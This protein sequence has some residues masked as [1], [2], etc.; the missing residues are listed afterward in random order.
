MNNLYPIIA[1]NRYKQERKYFLSYILTFAILF[2][3]LQPNIAQKTREVVITGEAQFATGKEIRLIVFDDLL[4]YQAVTVASTKISKEGSFRLTYKTNQIKLVQLAIQTSKAEFLVIPGKHYNFFID[5][6]LELFQLLDPLSYGGFLQIIPSE[7]DTTELNY[8]IRKFELFFD[9]LNEQFYPELIYHKNLKLR[10]SMATIL[11]EKFQFY[12]DPLDFYASYLY[13]SF[14]ILDLIIYQKSIDTIYKKYLDNEYILYDNPAYMTFFNSFY[15]NYLYNSPRISKELLTQFINQTPDY[16]AIF[17]E[18]GRDPSLRNERIRELVIIK[19]LREFYEDAQFSQ[20]NILILLEF[21]LKNTHFPEHKPIIKNIIIST[22][23]LHYNSE[24]PK[25]SLKEANGVDFKLEKLKGKWIYLQFFSSNCDDCIRE[26]MI[27]K[28]LKEKYKDSLVF[29]S[30]SLDFDFNDF[31]DF[32]QVY[33]IFDWQ[34]VHFNFQFDW[35]DELEINT[36]PDNILLTPKGRIALRDVPVADKGLATFLSR[37]FA[38]PD[39]EENPLS[40]HYKK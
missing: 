9:R 35:L 37:K 25:C 4:T 36:L 40:P 19:N 10:D 7:I 33:K 34:F 14:G 29:V 2:F 27:I 39:V 3:L 38:I 6:D 16:L 24:F 13:Y 12:Y 11:N 31:I 5:M 17:N 23:R 28:E 32:K 20:R 18:L 22:Q 8:R 26:M 30:V 15:D 21:I 1:K